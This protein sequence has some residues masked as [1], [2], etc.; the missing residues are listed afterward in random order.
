M[1][2]LLKSIARF[3]NG[4]NVAGKSPP[5]AAILLGRRQAEEIAKTR[6]SSRSCIDAGLQPFVLFIPDYL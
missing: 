5:V 6:A 3:A 1:T 2:V 4:I